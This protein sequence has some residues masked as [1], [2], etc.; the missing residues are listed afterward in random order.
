MGATYS[1]SRTAADSETLLWQ[2]AKARAEAVFFKSIA[3]TYPDLA[4]EVLSIRQLHPPD[5]LVERNRQRC[6]IS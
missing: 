3:N 5:E 1:Q 2:A 4:Y 6:T